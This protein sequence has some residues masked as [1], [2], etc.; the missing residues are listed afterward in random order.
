MKRVFNSFKSKN[1]QHEEI[2][3]RPLQP[4]T[5]NE[6]ALLQNS[7]SS[8]PSEIA[9]SQSVSEDSN[10]P[11]EPVQTLQ[12]D[13]PNME[14]IDWKELGE[15]A[16]DPGNDEERE[17]NLAETQKDVG[18]DTNFSRIDE[19]DARLK[20]LEQQKPSEMQELVSQVAASSSVETEGMF[21]E[22]KREFTELHNLQKSLQ[23]SFSAKLKYDQHKESLI[24]SLHKE[25]QEYKQDLVKKTVMPMINDLIM[26]IDGIQKLTE[27]HRASEDPLNPE[28]LLNQMDM[29]TED[30]EEVLYRQGV[31]PYQQINNIFDPLKQKVHSTEMTTDSEKE[32]KIAKRFRKGYEW[33]GKT[34]RKEFV[35]V[36]TLDKKQKVASANT[37]EQE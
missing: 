20:E 19:L 14:I 21:H 26:V 31:E 7:E 18:K 17:P 12:D 25:V 34:I 27:N 36:Y 28:Q 3:D 16:P 35:S 11:Q 24:D 37:D 29:I 15:V 30:I 1:K 6:A 5:E 4:A 9:P 22:L 33:D 2:D 8:E 23:E 10:T 32:R 13:E